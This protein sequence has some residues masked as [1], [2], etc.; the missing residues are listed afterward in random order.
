M[1]NIVYILLLL[2]VCCKTEIPKKTVSAGYQYEGLSY[3]AMA[4]RC[5]RTLIIGEDAGGTW[6]IITK[7]AGSTLVQGLLDGSDNPCIDF[8]LY[9][10][11]LYQ[12][13]Y[14]VV[15]PCCTDSTRITLNK[16]CC[17]ISGNFNCN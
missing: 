15:Q 8:D 14:K 5:L 16:R 2:L 4:A 10:C 3:S 11:G 1:R 9:G 7:P 6:T 12:L 17:N 13:Q